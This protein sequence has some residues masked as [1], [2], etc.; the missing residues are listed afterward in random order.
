MEPCDAV[1]R[2]PQSQP[3]AALISSGGGCHGRWSILGVPDAW[4][5][6]EPVNR[7]SPQGLEELRRMLLGKEAA[8]E[9]GAHALPFERGWIGFLSYELGAFFEPSALPSRRTL[10]GV[11][12]AGGWHCKAAAIHDAAAQAWWWT[13]DGDP[14]RLEAQ[15]PLQGALVDPLRAEHP[16]WN[17]AD[18][19]AETRQRI[20]DGA[21]FQA[22]L[23]QRWQ[24]RYQG[25]VRALAA[26]ALRSSAARYGA[27]I[28]CPD[29]AAIIS[30]SPELFLRVDGEGV[31]TTRPIKGTAPSARPPAELLASEKDGAELAMIVDLMR[32]DLARVCRPSSVRVL[33]PRRIETHR[34]VHHGVAEIEGRLRPGMDIVDL[35][36]ATFPPGSVTGA[37]KVAAMQLIDELEPSA[38]GPYC[39]AVGFVAASGEAEFNVAIRTIT[40]LP[41]ER[42]PNM[43]CEPATRRTLLYSAGCGV[44]ADSDPALEQAESELKRRVLD[45]TLAALGGANLGE[46][47]PMAGLRKT[48]ASDRCERAAPAEVESV[49]SRVAEP[50]PPAE[51]AGAAEPQS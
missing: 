45:Q 25:S 44:V 27:V 6:I 22:N 9:E 13:G 49:S 18:A 35:L 5:A 10:K 28:E 42:A 1:A 30:M 48:A 33:T 14:P 17:F 51:V 2:W 3:L 39:G 31:V 7:R 34:T 38:R 50:T 32:N 37:P 46:P 16:S 11:P 36:V 4:S 20:I 26:A 47:M 12:L 15:E 40:L 23:S 8:A 29:G 43:C 41:G 24:A 21:L 19:V